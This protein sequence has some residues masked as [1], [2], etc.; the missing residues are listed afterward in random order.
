MKWLEIIEFRT[1]DNGD[2]IDALDL[3]RQIADL[4]REQRP[5]NVKV[6]RHGT[7]ET[8]F[9]LHLHCD[10]NEPEI[11]GS[12]LGIKLVSILKDFGMVNHNIWVD[13]QDLPKRR[14]S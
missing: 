5:I 7:V 12:M 4:R 11:H 2:W 3:E 9:S 13:K 6:F 10:S 14:R 1:I 8:D